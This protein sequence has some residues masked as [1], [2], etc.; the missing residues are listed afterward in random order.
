MNVLSVYTPQ[1]GCKD[2]EK[3]TFWRKLD[4][5]LQSICTNEEMILAW[6]MNGHVGADRSGAERWSTSNHIQEW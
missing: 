5:I 1:T 3:D 2:N 6:G 4:D